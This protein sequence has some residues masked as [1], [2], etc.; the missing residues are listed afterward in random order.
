LL[1]VKWVCSHHGMACPE[2]ADGGR[3]P[4]DMEGFFFQWLYSPSLG[5]GLIFQF[6]NIFTQTVELLVR[7]ISPSQGLYLY[8][9]QHKHRKTHKH[10]N[11]HAS[12]GFEPTIPASERA[13]TVNVS[14]R[15]ATVPADMEV[16]CK[17]I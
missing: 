1:H 8:T 9:G 13:K 16:S 7:V 15:S 12:V 14:D 10:I 6:L 4:P 5:P 3:R 11:I 2:V 17:N